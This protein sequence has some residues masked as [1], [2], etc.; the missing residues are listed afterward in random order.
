DDPAHETTDQKLLGLAKQL[1][2]RVLT[3]DFNLNKVAQLQGLQVININD[4]AAAL[5][6]TVLPGEKMIVRVVK[7]GEEPGQGVGYLDDGTMVVL[8][9]GRDH[10]DEEVEFVV[11]KLHQTSAGRMI[12]GRVTG[13]GLA[14]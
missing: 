6:P 9:Q 14:A 12:F 5:R 13:Q 2:A 8:E 3:T 11:T 10:V 1:T 4:L 7:P